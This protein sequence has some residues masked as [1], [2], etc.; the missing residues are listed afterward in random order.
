MPLNLIDNEALRLNGWQVFRSSFRLRNLPSGGGFRHLQRVRIGE[1]QD[2]LDVVAG[3]EPGGDVSAEAIDRALSERAERANRA[4]QKKI[5]TGVSTVVPAHFRPVAPLVGAGEDREYDLCVIPFDGLLT[6]IRIAMDV[7]LAVN[8]ALSLRLES[9][10]S[11]FTSTGVTN[12]TDGL[13]TDLRPDFIGVNHLQTLL[14]DAGGIYAMTVRKPVMAGERVIAVIR[15]S[16]AIALNNINYYFTFVIASGE[17]VIET[18]KIKVKRIAAAEDPVVIEQE[19]PRAVRERA[20]KQEAV[21][22]LEMYPSWRVG[23]TGG[24]TVN[25]RDF[26]TAPY[27]IYG[28]QSVMVLSGTD[29]PEPPTAPEATVRQFVNSQYVQEPLD[30]P[31]AWAGWVAKIP[32]GKASPA[33]PAPAKEEVVKIPPPIKPVAKEPGKLPGEGLLFLA[34]LAP[35]SNFLGGLIPWPDKGEHTNTANGSWKHWS[36]SGVLLG[37]GPIQWVQTGGTIPEGAKL[38]PGGTVVSS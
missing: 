1:A 5:I 21:T 38:R 7:T 15:H 32:K 30:P 33:T 6:E 4:A 10:G 25:F 14:T 31:P 36:A 35:N 8:H 28:R 19:K 3:V 23:V 12:I 9:G 24:V 2:V 11:L 20:G 22:D 17:V 16:P 37:T 13:A 29:L 18:P 26:T 34:S 27:M